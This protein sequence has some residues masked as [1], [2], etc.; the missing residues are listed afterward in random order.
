MVCRRRAHVV[1]LASIVPAV[2]TCVL[3]HQS[4]DPGDAG[5]TTCPTGI[6]LLQTAPD[7]A[8]RHFSDRCELHR[9]ALPL[10]LRDRFDEYFFVRGYLYDTVFPP[11]LVEGATCCMP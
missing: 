9:D 10:P 1:V 4:V 11:E 6:F 5:D 3:L 8:G 7:G 2:G